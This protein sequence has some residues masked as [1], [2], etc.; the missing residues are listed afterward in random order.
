[1][2]LER[3]QAEALLVTLTKFIPPRA[4][5]QLNI[6]TNQIG[7]K[8]HT[9]KVALLFHSSVPKLFF[10]STSQPQSWKQPST[11]HTLHPLTTIASN[12]DLHSWRAAS[13]EEVERGRE[14]AS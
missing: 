4:L 13:P 3:D 11:V 9:E 12:R 10:H 8:M 6:S 2:H 5:Q 14:G 7:R 1:M